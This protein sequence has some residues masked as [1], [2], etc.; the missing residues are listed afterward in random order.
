MT[1]RDKWLLKYGG[2]CL[3]RR[4]VM[5]DTEQLGTYSCCIPAVSFTRGF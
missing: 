3:E 4:R 2:T 1:K 5:F